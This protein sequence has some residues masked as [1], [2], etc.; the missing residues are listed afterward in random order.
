MLEFFTVLRYAA[1]VAFGALGET[2]NQRAGSLNI[3]LEGQMLLAAFVGAMVALDAG[4]PWLGVLAGTASAVVFGLILSQFVLNWASDQVVVGAAANL[5][6]LGLTGTLYR[7]RFGQSGSLLN[8]P[9]LPKF[10]PGLDALL[11]V[12]LIAAPLLA[13]LIVRTKWGLA[14]RAAGDTPKAVEAAGFS[15]LSLRRQAWLIGSVFAGLAGSYL[16]LGIAGSFAENMTA[17]RGFVAIAM[18]TFGRWKPMWALAAA[19]LI[20]FAEGLQFRFQSLG[21]DLPFQLFIAL[22]YL[23]ALA[24]LVLVGKGAA[25]PAALGVPYRREG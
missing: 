14:L 11:V 12:L 9:T 2:V 6:A 1:P 19:L 17:G 24:V 13:W 25:T 21:L 5:F 20:G 4:N 18:V 22:P 8:V 7:A 23:L 10:G 16:A 3:G 15:V